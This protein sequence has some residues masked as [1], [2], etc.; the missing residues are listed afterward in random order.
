MEIRVCCLNCVEDVVKYITGCTLGFGRL[1][2]FEN[3]RP[4]TPGPDQPLRHVRH[5]PRGLGC[6]GAREIVPLHLNRNLFS[7]NINK[8]TKIFQTSDF[9]NFRFLTTLSY[10]YSN[11][12][13][14]IFSQTQWCM[15]SDTKRAMNFSCMYVEHCMT[16]HLKDCKVPKTQLEAEGLLSN[17]KQLEF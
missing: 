11:G 3:C 14:I 7:N 12:M 15:R 10:V 6:Q 5:V 9:S 17:M 8:I 16:S 13:D 4:T 1:E 2:I